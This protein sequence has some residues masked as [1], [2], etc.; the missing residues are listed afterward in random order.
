MKIRIWNVAYT[1]KFQLFPLKL[2]DDLWQWL[3]LLWIVR[4]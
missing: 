3:W 1:P 4:M 2:T